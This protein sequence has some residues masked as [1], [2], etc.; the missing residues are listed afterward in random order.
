MP[1][2]T[3]TPTLTP[4]ADLP[5]VEL[6]QLGPA[7]DLAIEVPHGATSLAEYRGLRARLQ[8]AL[9]DDLEAFFCVN[10]DAGAPEVARALAERRAARG[11][12]TLIVRCRV[13]RTFVD[14]NRELDPAR[15]PAQ[16][17]GITPGMAPYIRDPA[18]REL[19]FD[20]HRRYLEATAAALEPVMAAGGRA[21]LLHTYAPRSVDVVVDDQIV[22][23][24][25]AA[26]AEPERWPLRPEADL[27]GQL[28]DGRWDVPAEDRGAMVRAFAE[29]GL[30]LTL[31]ATYPLHPVTVAHRW[32]ARWPG[33]VRCVELRRDL[34]ADP[35][36]PFDE[37]RISGAAAQRFARALQRALDG[38]A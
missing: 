25:R 2:A 14:C 26:W 37:Q 20:L 1:P 10:T 24:L 22:P 29:E 32:A 35:W 27:I 36:R 19:L 12:G 31:G 7:P 13:P 5:V 23:A 17:G 9:P 16:V 4:S 15:P 33:R 30:Q 21:L 8:G 18:D 6:L 3:P 34:L 38:E 28:P 11:R